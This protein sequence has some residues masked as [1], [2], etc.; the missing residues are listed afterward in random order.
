P[1]PGY[2]LQRLLPHVA[3]QLGLDL[4]AGL[5]ELA[6]AAGA[7]LDAPVGQEIERCDAFRHP[8]GMV[9][10]V[11]EQRDPV[12][13]PD[14]LGALRDRREED[15]GS[16]GVR[17]LRQE[18]VL[19]LPDGVV[20]QLVREHDLFE[21]LVVARVRGAGA[22]RL[23]HRELVEEVEFHGRWVC[24]GTRRR[25]KGRRGTLR[26]DRWRSSPCR[27][28]TS[29]S[30]S[31]TRPRRTGS[32]AG[33]TRASSTTPSGSER[34]PGPDGSRSTSAAG[35]ASSRPAWRVAAGPQSAPAAP[36]P[37]ARTPA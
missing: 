28:A 36:A 25:C 23:R 8:D 21:R 4:E 19:D 7:E 15:L 29:R 11:R 17:E 10:L 34:V 37:G 13:Q 2:D 32:G 33:T 27:G 5:L 16:G 1:H 18:V 3:R 12:S 20:A 26:W 24:A 31:A 35:R 9:E 6:R 30:T 22:V 14:A